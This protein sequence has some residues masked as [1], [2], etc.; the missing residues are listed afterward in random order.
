MIRHLV[1]EAQTAEPA[2]GEV[3]MHLLTQAPLGPQPHHIANDQ[4]P[5]HEFGVD[6]RSAGVTVKAAHIVVQTIQIQKAIN[7]PEKMVGRDMR[8]EIKLVEQ[9][10]VNLLPSKHRKPSNSP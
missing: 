6:R 8:L 4:H 10:G 9:P 3:E 2:V 1:L 7:S 5:D